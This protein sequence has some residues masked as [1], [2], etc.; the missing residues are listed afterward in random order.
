MGCDTALMS[1]GVT[2]SDKY[3]DMIFSCRRVLRDTTEAAQFARGIIRAYRISCYR[4]MPPTVRTGGNG[5]LP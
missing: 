1:G 3:L 4:L 2:V 5:P